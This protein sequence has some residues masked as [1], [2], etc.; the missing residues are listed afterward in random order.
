VSGDPISSTKFNT[1]VQ[2]LEA[3]ANT[4]RPIVAGGT[5]ASTASAARTNLGL[6]I[7]VNVQAYDAGLLSIAGLTTL[8]DRSI[9]TTAS[10]T[11]AVYT[12]TAAGRAILDDA[13]AA[14][15]R[16]TLGLGTA[17][18]KN[19]GTSGDAVPLLNAANTF[20][21]GQTFTNDIFLNE[22]AGSSKEFVYQSGG[23]Y[24]WVVAAN[25]E[26]ETGS[27][28]GTNFVIARFND[29]G[30]F[31]DTPLILNRATGALAVAV[32]PTVSGNTVW[33]AG[34]DG[35]AS[36]LDADLID[37]VQPSAFALTILDDAD[38]AAVRTTIGAGIGDMLKSDNLSGLTNYATARTNLG[39]AIGT[40]VQAL[41]ATLTALA[42][43][44]TGA[45][46]LPYS[47][48]T[49]TF[50]QADFTAF[51]RSLVDD[52][53]AS[54]ARTTLGLANGATTTIS[55]FALTMLD[56]VDAA[57]VRTTIGVGLGTGD[58]VA[59]NNLSDV[60][61]AS[62]ARTNLGLAIGTNV[63]AYDAG[64]QSIAGLTTEADRGIY[65]TAS[66]TYAVYTLT[67]AGRAILDDADASAQRTTLGL[68]T[69]AIVN[70]GTSGATIPLL[71]AANT[72]SDTVTATR[73]Q[74]GTFLMDDN[75]GLG[76]DIPGFNLDASDWLVYYR[77]DNR[78]EVGIGGFNSFSVTASGCTIGGN[79]VWHAGNDGAGS[80][81]DADTLDGVQGSDYATLTGT[82]TLTNKTLTSP[83]INGGTI[84]SRSQAASETTGTLT[85]AS[86]NK[87]IQ[88][89]GDIT[90]PNAVFAA[91][92]IIL[93]YAGASSRTITE[94]SSVT[95]R[96]GGSSTTGSR[97]LAA[98]GVAVLFFVS[99]SEVVVSGGAVT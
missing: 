82:Q 8:A 22:A 23:L 90:I 94:G 18:V 55:A 84:Q 69:A 50:A 2:D 17:A 10:D 43:L 65:T 78:L 48:G 74:V 64:L 60:A 88:A 52:A 26:A 3:D 31:I 6:E 61:N 53:D 44:A 42:G 51:G 79:V 4:D 19:T 56:D 24:R 37:G 95:M 39:L 85:V 72:F 89:T 98:R 15:Q 25:S 96:L 91:G 32:T 97:T 62:T 57:A 87:T 14:A 83:T 49:D 66:D 20:G 68:G 9:Y 58:L 99:S 5:G 35:A 21:A 30:S 1:L 40:D 86:A 36:G 81:L 76:V 71:N 75:I 93:I 47:T 7:G 27:N 70:T 45:D 59:A 29:A 33:H 34:N 77:A 41:D 38:A 12:L 28:A 80:G 46:K 73:F 54:A 92:D 13:D 63:Q 11:Y 16:T 67:S